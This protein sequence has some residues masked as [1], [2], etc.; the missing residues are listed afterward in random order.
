MPPMRTS[1]IATLTFKIPEFSMSKDTT[2]QVDM[3]SGMLEEL[4]CDMILVGTYYRPL[5]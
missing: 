5:M 3:D 4:V 1:R 2:W